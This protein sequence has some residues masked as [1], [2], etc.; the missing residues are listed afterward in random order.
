MEVQGSMALGLV[1]LEKSFDQVPSEMVMATLR[2]MGVTEAELRMVEG[3]YE[4]TTARV[5]VG[6]GASEEFEVK[7]GLRQGSVLSSLLFIAVL[8]LIKRK[9]MMKDATRKLLY[10]DDRTLVA[11]GK[12][13]LHE[14]LA[15]WDGLFTR[16]GLII[17]LEKTEV[18][19]IGHQRA[20]LDIELEGKKRTQGDSF[21]YLGG[22]VC[23]DGKT[24]R[25]RE[26][27]VR[28]RVHGRSKRVESN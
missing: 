17:N 21:L 26:V 23:V 6:E 14:T 27:D 1:D 10:A 28:R 15:D 2:W 12:H 16:H 19:H 3:V 18:L 11:N 22:A 13:E 9:T 5:V 20:G 24:G 8:D 4:K 25:R 7:I